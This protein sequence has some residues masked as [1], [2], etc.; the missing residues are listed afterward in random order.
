MKA[1]LHE[2][3]VN[4]G[5]FCAVNNVSLSFAPG[6]IHALVG[7]NG[8]G[9]STAMSVLFGLNTDYQGNIVI[10]NQHRRWKSPADAI[11]AGVG[12]V[13]QHFMLQESMSVLEN[14]I[15]CSEPVNKLGFVSF[16]TA[17]KSVQN[18]IDSY[19]LQIDQTQK[20]AELSVGQR[21]AVEILKLLYRRS[22]LLIL[23]EPTAVL[24]PNEKNELFQSLSNFKASGKSIILITHKIDEVMMIADKVSVMRSGKLISSKLLK[25]TSKD[26][27][28]Q[29]IIGGTLPK[30]IKRKQMYP[31]NIGFEMQKVIIP[32]LATRRKPISLKVYLG[33][34]VGIAGVSGN[35]QTALVEAIVGLRNILSGNMLLSNE[36]ISDKDVSAR[37]KT[38]L[39]YIPEDRQRVGLALDASVIENSCVSQIRNKKFSNGYFFNLQ[40]L[41]KFS[42]QLVSEYD[43]RVGTVKSKVRTMS[44]GNKQKLVVAR[45]LKQKKQLVIAENPTW[46]VDIGAIN[47]I[48][49]ELIKMRDMGHAILLVSNEI[50]EIMGLSDRIYVMAN[51]QLSEPMS[52]A[53]V[54]ANKLGKLMLSHNDSILSEK[55]EKIQP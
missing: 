17:A 30:P 14:V 46:G 44:G 13:H 4:F 19:D 9:K 49:Q 10:N 2:I 42:E 41:R 18:L 11:S 39:S 25:N 51:G 6:E 38:G 50:E 5:A 21:Q 54:T 55:L 40:H 8:A 28:Q 1:E 53:Q 35:G 27:I 16:A 20:V 45:E 7:E 29:N 32:G 26:E 33:E 34:I 48:H 15:L 36:T 22:D 47:K 3:S 43:I 23:D 12:M 31:K 52:S 24:T 37:R